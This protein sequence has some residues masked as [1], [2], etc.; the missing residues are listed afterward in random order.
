MGG[1]YS[2]QWTFLKGIN[3]YEFDEQIE[4]VNICLIPD[5][6]FNAILKKPTIY[7]S[8]NAA[9]NSAEETV[10]HHF[11]KQLSFLRR[12]NFI[13]EALASFRKRKGQNRIA[14]IKKRLDAEKVDVLFFLTQSGFDIDFPYMIN[15]WDL[16]HKTTYAFP[17]IAMQ[18]NYIR[19]EKLFSALLNKALLILC[20]SEA[21]I[22]EL[23]N[24]YGI[25]EKKLK[26]LPMFGNMELGKPVDALPVLE[27]FSLEDNRFFLYPAQFWSL[28]NHYNLLRAFSLFVAT[29]PD[30]KMIFCGSDKGNMEYIKS[31]V[32]DLKLNDKVIF[33]GFVSNDDLTALYQTATAM[34]FPTFLGPTNMP[35]LEAARLKC[36]VL[37]SDLEGHK[38]QLGEHALYFEPTRP[39]EIEA[40]M[41]RIADDPVFRIT[42]KE[43]AYREFSQSKF[44]LENSLS[45]LNDI[46]LEAK[47]IRKT[48]GNLNSN[49]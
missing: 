15:Y 21:G 43:A 30:Y 45:F 40:A 16:A 23:K 36:P 7:V 19:R 12:S 32:E 34:V 2:Y 48:W 8:D 9:K 46:F 39:H 44:R 42:L 38:E 14:A 13:M 37:C 5:E 24:A 27:K 20:E 33:A 6:T 25:F 41:N 31:V 49:T 28:K 10:S 35:L 1:T 3:E 11:K 22:K 4:I 26:L 47:A 29:H 18:D 17:E